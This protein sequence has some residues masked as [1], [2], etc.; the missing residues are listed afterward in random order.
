MKLY[1]FKIEDSVSAKFMYSELLVA[2]FCLITSLAYSQ[3]RCGTHIKWNNHTYEPYQPQNEISSRS[4]KFEIPIIFHIFTLTGEEPLSERTIYE[5]IDVLNENYSQV[6]A[7]SA[8]YPEASVLAS[9][10]NISFYLSNKDPN[11]DPATGMIH[12]STNDLSL[13]NV[14]EQEEPRKVM[15]AI[16]G[17]ADPWDTER[18]LNI[19]ISP[20]NDGILGDSSFPKTGDS[21]EDGVV[22]KNSVVGFQPFNNRF[23]LGKTLVHEIGHYLGLR[24]PF[25]GNE[26]CEDNDG[27]DD[28]PI[29][30]SFYF[31]CP[32]YPQ[33]SCGSLDLIYNFMDFH[34]DVC[35]RFFTKGQVDLIHHTLNICRAE[36]VN[37]SIPTSDRNVRINEIISYHDGNY[38]IVHDRDFRSL[39]IEVKVMD[40]SGR[41]IRHLDANNESTIRINSNHLIS[42]VYLLLLERENNY[43]TR[44]IFISN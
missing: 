26:R 1:Y 6:N 12:Y 7:P 20:R 38:L 28:T 10:P 17:G 35:L 43:E 31:G 30:N 29:H 19:Y 14:P 34:D 2:V 41:V 5:Q 33:E 24:H 9:N 36:L 15:N 11:G 37:Q 18:Y 4:S 27:I 42:G 16:L 39:N 8:L 44:K 23:G 21:A 13:G 32:E 25:G 22:I 40:I 3:D